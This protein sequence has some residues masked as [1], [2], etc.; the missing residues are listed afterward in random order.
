MCVTI[1]DRISDQDKFAEMVSPKVISLVSMM[2]ALPTDN[3]R[4]VLKYLRSLTSL[5]KVIIG[6]LP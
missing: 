2:S 6:I 1:F 3:L 4:L 5:I